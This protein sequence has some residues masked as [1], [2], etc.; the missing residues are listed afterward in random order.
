M[1]RQKKKTD[2]DMREIEI[3]SEIKSDISQYVFNYTK[4]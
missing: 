2:A 1:D 3:D 4:V